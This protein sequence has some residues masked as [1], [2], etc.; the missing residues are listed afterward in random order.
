VKQKL[1]GW[2]LAQG[3]SQLFSYGPS[4]PVKRMLQGWR[5]AMESGF[6]RQPGKRPQK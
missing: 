4:S 3:K 6:V 2:P 5:W 1:R